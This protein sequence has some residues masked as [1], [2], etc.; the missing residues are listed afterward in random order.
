MAVVPFVVTISV[1][2]WT[3]RTVIAVALTAVDLFSVV[4]SAVEVPA[5]VIGVVVMASAVVVS[6][7]AVFTV[8]L[9]VSL[10]V[11]CDIVVDV[12]SPVVVLSVELEVV[13][14]E[15]VTAAVAVSTVVNA[16][17]ISLT[18][19]SGCVVTAFLVVVISAV[20]R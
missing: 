15:D 4:T 8:V 5:E 17:V 1:L 12:V 14:D 2:L 9:P 16:I 10:S 13:S 7:A 11:S 20:N 19:M 6:S 3:V 18:A